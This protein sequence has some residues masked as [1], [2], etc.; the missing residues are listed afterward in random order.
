[1]P[2]KLSEK[3]SASIS[4]GVVEGHRNEDAGVVGLE[5]D[6]S[7]GDGKTRTLSRAAFIARVASASTLMGGVGFGWLATG[8]RVFLW[9]IFPDVTF[10]L[11]PT[12]VQGGGRFDSDSEWVG[13]CWGNYLVGYVQLTLQSRLK[14]SCGQ[15]L[16]GWVHGGVGQARD[17]SCSAVVE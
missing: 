6:W 15:A 4:L 10:C 13:G 8:C 12:V 7:S 14:F 5:G 16:I 2:L 3:P 1:M 11:G 9:S 17:V